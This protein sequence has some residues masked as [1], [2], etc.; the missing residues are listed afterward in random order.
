[1]TQLVVFGD[2][3]SDVGT[4]DVGTVAALGGG[5]WTVNSNT[6]KNWT[7]LLAAQYGLPAPCP[8]Q[9]GLMSII[10]GF[11]GAAVQ[12]F[13]NCRNYAQGSSRISSPFGPSSYALQ[14]ALTAAGVPA[15][16]NSGALGVLAEPVT[17]Q[18]AQHLSNVN[19]TYSGTELVAVLAGAND[20]FM[21]LNAISGAAGNSAATAIG[22]A[23]FADWT[24][25]PN[26][27]SIETALMAPGTAAAENASVQA[28]QA[29]MALAA[30]NLANAIKSQVIAKGA[31]HVVVI[32]VPDI[33]TSPYI[34]AM[35]SPS[36]S[37]LVKGLTSLYNSTLQAGLSGTGV[38]IVDAFTQSENQVN[39]P[40]QFGLTNVSTPAC[41]TTSSANPL[42]GSSL[43]CT[44]ASTLTGVDTSAYLFA[45]SVHPTPYGYKLLAQFVI[46]NLYAAGIQ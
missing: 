14:L 5:K 3:L 33:S 10:P 11:T 37:A 6:A 30:T 4:Y 18:M 15:S 45:D 23:Q 16:S 39:N 28:A 36:T 34:A 1:L 26:W 27:T 17:T 40:S 2:S 41:S 32:N 12:N 8:A 9:K 31:K 13:P 29:Y 7:E 24:S 43:T 19:N 21:N 20:V 44:A 42:Q 35:N 25:L 46:S 22:A 38:L